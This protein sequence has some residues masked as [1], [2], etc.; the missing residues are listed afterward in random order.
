MVIFFSVQLN[1]SIVNGFLDQYLWPF[2]PPACILAPKLV[3]LA[4]ADLAMIMCIAFSVF[5]YRQCRQ[6][7][8]N[9]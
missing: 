1:I 7:P 2:L 9:R 6:R 8:G 4:G 3:D 5:H